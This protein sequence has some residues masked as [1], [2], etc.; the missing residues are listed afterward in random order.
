[1][2]N[3]LMNHFFADGEECPIQLFWPIPR[4]EFMEGYLS[5]EQL[6]ETNNCIAQ[7]LN[8]S[9]ENFVGRETKCLA[10]FMWRGK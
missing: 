4:E 3:E 7:K 9:R 5:I 1:M 8:L 10:T 6:D 2:H